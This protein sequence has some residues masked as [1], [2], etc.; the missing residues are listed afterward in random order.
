[1]RFSFSFIQIRGRFCS[2]L[3]LTR[4][5]RNNNRQA[6]IEELTS[7]GIIPVEHDLQEHP[8]KSLDARAWLMGRVAALIDE[9]LSAKDIVEGMVNDAA[10]V[11]QD[12]ASKVTVSTKAK[13]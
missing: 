9:V 1:M 10:R 3:S 2:S 4:N 5:V 12:N 11:L 7:K 13:L 6:E 8:E